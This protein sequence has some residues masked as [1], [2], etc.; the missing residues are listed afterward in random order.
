M[1]FVP[2]IA[3][4]FYVVDLVS[5]RHRPM[6]QLPYKSVKGKRSVFRACTRKQEERWCMHNWR[7][8][9][10]KRVRCQL[11]PQS[12]WSSSPAPV[13]QRPESSISDQPFPNLEWSRNG[14]I[15]DRRNCNKIIEPKC[16]F[17]L[18]TLTWWVDGASLADLHRCIWHG[19]NHF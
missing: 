19:P 5:P 8:T 4:P 17:M 9:L 1:L 13:E 3:A 15:V 6:L 12:D 7:T 2:Q 18:E 10:R 14:L 11:M 16:N